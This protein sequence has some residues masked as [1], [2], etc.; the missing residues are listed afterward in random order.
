MYILRMKAKNEVAA[1]NNQVVSQIVLKEHAR[2]KFTQ[3]TE[4]MGIEK[5]LT[6][7]AQG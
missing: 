3:T 6:S 1:R 7:M 5:I 4:I 2:D